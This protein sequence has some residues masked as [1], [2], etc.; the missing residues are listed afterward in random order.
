[1]TTIMIIIVMIMTIKMMM[2]MIITKFMI[3]IAIKLIN[4]NY[5]RRNLPPEELDRQVVVPTRD[6]QALPRHHPE[7]MFLAHLTI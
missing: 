3:M 4:V 6:L 7:L 2:M 5:E 1:M